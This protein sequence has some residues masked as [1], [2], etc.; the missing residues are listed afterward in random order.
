ML[1]AMIKI[2]LKII[3]MGKELIQ[4]LI[5]HFILERII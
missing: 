2:I 5:V 4:L 3:E 1:S